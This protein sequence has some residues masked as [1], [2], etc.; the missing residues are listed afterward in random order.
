MKSSRHAV[1]PAALRAENVSQHPG[2]IAEPFRNAPPSIHTGTA[3][4]VSAPKQVSVTAEGSGMAA[5]ETTVFSWSPAQAVPGQQVLVPF[6]PL[7]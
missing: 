3:Y 7:P 5:L 4:G 2:D 1:A 6:N